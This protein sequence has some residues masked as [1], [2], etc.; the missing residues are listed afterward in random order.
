M[1]FCWK[2]GAKLRGTNPAFCSEC[3]VKLDDG[4]NTI[5]E[6]Q[7]SSFNNNYEEAKR[8]YSIKDYNQALSYINSAIA[9]DNA[10]Y[11]YYNLKAKILICTNKFS[12]A[13]NVLDLSFNIKENLEAL[14]QKAYC[15]YI[16]NNIEKAIKFFL[17]YENK[18][19][20]NAEFYWKLAYFYCVNNDKNNAINACDKAININRTCG[21]AYTYKAIANFSNGKTK[22]IMGDLENSFKYLNTNNEEYYVSKLYYASNFILMT[23]GCLK[24]NPKKVFTPMNEA[25][26]QLKEASDFNRKN[27]LFYNRGFDIFKEYLLM[28]TNENYF[29]IDVRDSFG[30][31]VSKLWQDITDICLKIS[32]N[33]S[34]IYKFK[35]DLYGRGGFHEKAIYYFDK[36][37][38]SDEPDFRVIGYKAV[39]LMELGKYQ[40]AENAFKQMYLFLED[41]LKKDSR[42]IYLMREKA[43]T[44][45]QLGRRR[46]ALSVYDEIEKINPHA[47]FLAQ[48]KARLGFR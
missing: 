3:G 40:E 4:T 1:K 7:I 21:E 32:P 25:L 12:D 34:R 24:D 17:E 8:L 11:E 22:D 14:F 13:L 20:N 36:V 10:N 45:I 39:S 44:L 2:C 18:Y 16:Q 29:N 9:N 41:E 23:N 28:A 31:N 35:G 6:P 43:V 46:D 19:L 38:T 47:E 33:D 37:L 26:S 5:Q 42:N 30:S 27:V 15:F 48:D